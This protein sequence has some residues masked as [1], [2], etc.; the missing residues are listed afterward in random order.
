MLSVGAIAHAAPEPPTPAFGSSI[1]GFADYDA[2]STCD[3]S[4]KPGAKDFRSLMLS[5]YPSS[6]NLGI[7]RA[8]DSGG[9]SEHKEGRAFDWGLNYNDS[10]Q[11]DIA[12]T[13]IDW[14]L[15]TDEH[16][17]ACALARRVG[18]MYFIWNKQIW[19][20][21]RAPN[22]SCAT[23]GW[24]AY[25]GTNPHTDHIHLSWA[26]PGARQQTT[27]WTAPLPTN[28]PPKGYLDGA[29][30]EAIGGWSQDLDTPTSANDVHLYFDGPAGD[31][32]ATSVSLTANQYR[33]D[34]CAAVGSCEHAF[35][36]ASPLSLH[37]G[38]EHEVYAYGIDTSGGANSQLSNSPRS[39]RCEP[40]VPAGVLRHVANPDVFAAWGFSYFWDVMPV[41]DSELDEH[42]TGDEL[43]QQPVLARANDGSPSVYLIE[44]DV[45]RH[46]PSPDVMDTWG[47]DWNAIEV[48][49]AED[50]ESLQLGPDVRSRPVLVQGSGA[51]VYLLDDD[52][53]EPPGS[54]SGSGGSGW[55][56]GGAGTGSS[57]NQGSGASSGTTSA[58]GGSGTG[59]ATSVRS[60]DSGCACSSAGK[61][62]SA[63]GGS[64][65]QLWLALAGIL[66]AL[67]R[68]RE[69][70]T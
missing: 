37:D 55:G 45:K 7:I 17:N 69:E 59:P 29:D 1:D 62:A 66:A 5:T 54:G 11:R 60:S 70:A 19:G 39:F 12:N 36:V 43:P 53:G 16:G 3:P 18:L 22:G 34:L 42:E 21:Y 52:L 33:E 67:R 50:L 2:Q 38:Q 10:T 8:C 65:A 46:I 31:A 24:K 40:N 9:T 30:C 68:R 15:R 49:Q 63:F 13:A 6:S 41:S 48:R 23:A 57:G 4:E 27:W 61:S 56:A 14:L 25:T 47:F 64:S 26:W 51:A 20:S 35:E 32:N 28:Q 44:G 58:E